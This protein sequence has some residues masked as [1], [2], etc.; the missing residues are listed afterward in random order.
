MVNYRISVTDELERKA[1]IQA[2]A[3]DAAN[4]RI[5]FN[6]RNGKEPLKLIHV[7]IGLLLYRLENYRTRDKQLSLIAKQKYQKGFFDPGR[8]EDVSVQSAQHEILLEEAMQGRGDSIKPI[9]GELMRVRKQTEDLII[10]SDGVILNGNRRVAAMRELYALDPTTY[11]TFSEILCA[12]LPRNALADEIRSLE[13]ALQMQPDTKLPYEWTALGR[14]ARDLLNDKKSEDEIAVQMNRDKKDISRAIAKLEA[15]DLY[16][17]EW[18]GTPEDYSMLDETEQAFNQIATRNNAA[19][20]DPNIKEATRSFDFFLVEQRESLMDRAYK[21]INTIEDNS[22]AFL[23]Q[24]ADA[25]NV[26]LGKKNIGATSGQHAIQFEDDL[27]EEIDYAP[28]LDR[29]QQARET[30]ADKESTS[31]IIQGVCIAVG[32]QDRNKDRAALRF[33][34]EALKKLNAI[35]L[36]TAGAQTHSDID[37]Q[38][39]GILVKANALLDELAAFGYS[40]RAK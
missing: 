14:A 28:L 22:E 1:L 16:L 30:T 40:G 18:L 23:S 34:Q 11:A 35:D 36:T 7:P 4:T 27:Q 21:F 12:V 17:M 15:A 38:L 13:I 6:F 26:P 37:S 19:G 29:L 39:N 25:L 3:I 8:R 2:R 5:E 33:A 31:L 24:V 10:S 9:Y 32:E 20:R